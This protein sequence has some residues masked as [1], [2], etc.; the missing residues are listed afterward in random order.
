MASRS[1][2]KQVMQEELQDEIILR[3]PYLAFLFRHY[4]I[5]WITDHINSGFNQKQDVSS[6]FPLSYL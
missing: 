2:I 4:C 1:H 5:P 6:S 3:K